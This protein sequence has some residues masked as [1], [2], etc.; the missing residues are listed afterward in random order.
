MKNLMP[1]RIEAYLVNHPAENWTYL[2]VPG[3]VVFNYQDGI[4]KSLSDE[5]EAL[6]H[7]DQMVLELKRQKSDQIKLVPITTQTVA[8][9]R[10]LGGKVRKLY[11][12]SQ[13]KAAQLDASK[14]IQLRQAQ[15]K[16][17]SKGRKLMDLIERD[18]EIDKRALENFDKLTEE[19]QFRLL[20]GEE[21]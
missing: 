10:E 9:L 12:S 18:L 16:F 21:E 19:Q 20:I 1:S 8:H 3:S 15:L 14:K 13:S 5:E 17:Q 6:D 11:E 2:H 4:L 7:M